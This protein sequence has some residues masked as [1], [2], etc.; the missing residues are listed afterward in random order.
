[1]SDPSHG[2]TAIEANSCAPHRRP[3]TWAIAASL[4]KT[5]R[6][7]IDN[8]IIVPATMAADGLVIRTPTASFAGIARWSAGTTAKAHETSMMDA[9]APSHR[10]RGPIRGWLLRKQQRRLPPPRHVRLAQPGFSAG[11]MCADE[12]QSHQRLGHVG[13][14]N[15]P[16]RPCCDCWCSQRWPLTKTYLL[17]VDVTFSKPALRRSPETPQNPPHAASWAHSP[18]IQTPQ[19]KHVRINRTT[20]RKSQI[21]PATRRT[22]AQR[23]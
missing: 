12:H 21:T 22:Q 1:M 10:A 13:V 19:K 15:L 23:M 18:P 6:R 14:N 17:L 20:T 16:R 7:G 4:V 2:R 11:H 3:G 9:P 5:R 8:P